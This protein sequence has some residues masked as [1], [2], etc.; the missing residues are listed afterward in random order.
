MPFI[1]VNLWEG[2]SKEKKAAMA[3]GITA[4]VVKVLE[5]PSEAVTVVFNDVPKQ[6][7]CIGG[8]PC[9]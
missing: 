5:C 3:Q 7:W 9:A 2:H 8:K 6:D 4:A 1:N